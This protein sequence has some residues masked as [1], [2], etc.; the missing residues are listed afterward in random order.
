M[1]VNRDQAD[2]APIA[3]RADQPI[4][5]SGRER[6][7]EVADELV[8]AITNIIWALIVEQR[9]AQK[10]RQIEDL[11]QT[12]LHERNLDRFDGVALP[13]PVEPRPKLAE[14]RHHARGIKTIEIQ[15]LAEISTYIESNARS[16]ERISTGGQSRGG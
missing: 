6:L 8:V 5:V 9:I 16:I 11:L 3:L 15:E 10:L 13:H 4:N 1:R 12:A 7:V 2:G 14:E